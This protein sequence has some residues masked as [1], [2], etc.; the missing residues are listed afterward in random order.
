[1]REAIA[2]AKKLSGAPDEVALVELPE[3]EDSLLGTL[4]KLVGLT[5]ARMGLPSASLPPL[6]L[7]IARSLAP[8]LVFDASAPLALAEVG[9]EASFGGTLTR[10]TAED[11]SR[12]LP[13]GTAV[14]DP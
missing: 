12:P 11:I 4:L 14:T 7:D 13:R 9:E 5:S 6:F 3:E 10:P 1:L 2:E 8:F